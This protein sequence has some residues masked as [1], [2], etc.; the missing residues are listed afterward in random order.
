MR[1]L[2]AFILL[3]PLQDIVA[4]EILESPIDLIK[5]KKQMMFTNSGGHQERYFHK[6]DCKGFYYE[7]FGFE[8]TLSNGEPFTFIDRINL[9]VYKKGKVVGDYYDSNEIL[10]MI[11]SKTKDNRLGSL[12]LVGKSFDELI[13]SIGKP[14]LTLSNSIIYQDSKF[15]TLILKL[16]NEKV[17]WI[18]YVWMNTDFKSF[19]EK[20]ELIEK[21]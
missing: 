3:F 7:Y 11:K 13:N 9:I 4:Q 21:F 14:T 10:I 1:I 15:R 6:P 12:N 17:T 18:K 16:N 5:F 2:I 19:S 8:D 20:N